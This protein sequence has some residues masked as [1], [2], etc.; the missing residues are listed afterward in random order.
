MFIPKYFNFN[1]ENVR[2]KE[3]KPK[4]NMFCSAFIEQHVRRPHCDGDSG[5]IIATICREQRNMCSEVAAV[6]VKLTLCI[7]SGNMLLLV[8]P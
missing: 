4:R 6:T 5:Q 2:K 3:K 8:P 1:K 7:P